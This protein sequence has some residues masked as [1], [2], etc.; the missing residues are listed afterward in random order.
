[1]G[2]EELVGPWDSQWLRVPRPGEQLGPVLWEAFVPGRAD[3][4]DMSWRPGQFPGR[5]VKQPRRKSTL[6]RKWGS[7]CR[8]Q[9]SREGFL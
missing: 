4:E 3:H 6:R 1:M 7:W 5:S 2:L 8:G 9:G